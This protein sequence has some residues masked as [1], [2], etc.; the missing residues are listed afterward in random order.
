MNLRMRILN[1]MMMTTMVRIMG[2]AKDR[3][4]ELP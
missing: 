2:T 3:P 4:R 1:L